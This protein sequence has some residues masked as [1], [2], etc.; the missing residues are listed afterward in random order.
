MIA[1]ERAVRDVVLDVKTALRE[2]QTS[3]E[4]I[5]AS[6]ASRLAQTENLR[7]LLA[8][9]ETLEALTPEFLALK[10]S[11]QDRL[12]AAQREESAAITEYNKALARYRQALG[13]ALAERRIEVRPEPDLRPGERIRVGE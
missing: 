7:T 2:V 10:F 9:E 11:R 3:Y 13:T 12:A 6:R 4:L 5:E 1:L 8:R